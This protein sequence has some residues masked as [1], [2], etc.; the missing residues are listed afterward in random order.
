MKYLALAMLL[1]VVQASRPVPRQACDTSTGRGQAVQKNAAAYQQPPNGTR[2][3][4]KSDRSKTNKTSSSAPSLRAVER[5]AKANEDQ[6]TEIQQSAEKTD[7]MILLAAQEA[8]NGKVATEAAKKS[9]DAA[10]ASADA[11]RESILLTHRPRLHVRD[12]VISWQALTHRGT[13]VQ[14]LNESELDD[15]QLG[16]AFYIV[17]VG[18]QTATVVDLE[19]FLSFDDFLPLERPCEPGV[20]GFVTIKLK[21]GE[22][23]KIPFHPIAIG[24]PE[25]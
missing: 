22:A 8:E 20:R 18:N 9:A 16:G 2:P 11:A 19:Q 5:Q 4:E 24:N 23:R 3:V 15:W 1:A 12:V 10:Q 13:C 25:T 7:R 6:L 21:P 14:K 17:N